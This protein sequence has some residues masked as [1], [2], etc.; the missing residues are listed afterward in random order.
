MRQPL[1][2]IK[3]LKKYFPVRKGIFK[4]TVGHVKAVDGLDFSIFQ[5]ETLGLVGESGCGKSTTGR[6]ILQLLAPTEGEVLYEG[7][8]LTQMKAN[9]LRKLRRD[10][11]M[12]FQDPYASL[13]PRLTVGELIAEPLQIHQLYSGKEKDRRVDELLHVV[14]LNSYHAK[15]YAHEFSGGQRQR[16]GIARALA[17]SP[18][19]IVADEPVSALDVSI[20][21][22]VINLLQDLQEQYQLTYLFIAHDLSVVKHISDRVGVMY[23]GRIVELADKQDLYDSPLHPYTKALLSAVP[24]PNPLVKKER[25]V[26]QGDVPS[27]ANP[28]SGCT[29]H[30][31]C[32]ACMDICRTEK[33]AFQKVDGRYVACHLYK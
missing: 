28:P 17:L 15:R 19:L 3:N 14:G 23:L 22:Q 10:L 6:T 7:K 13:D 29:F 18:K 30:P 16:I 26:L 31:R 8:N 1:V 2:E 33:P 9:E 4:R 12:V 24:V 11:Q 25:I 5:G 20:Q 27:P 32:S 21:S